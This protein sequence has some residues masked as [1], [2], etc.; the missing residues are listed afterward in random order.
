MHAALYEEN[1]KQYVAFQIDNET[2]PEN[3]LILNN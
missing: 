3:R 2:L 1:M